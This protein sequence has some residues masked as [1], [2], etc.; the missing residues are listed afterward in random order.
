MFKA[1]MAGYEQQVIAKVASKTYPLCKI[2][3]IISQKLYL[4]SARMQT[5]D[6]ISPLVKDYASPRQRFTLLADEAVRLSRRL[7]DLLEYQTCTV[8]ERRCLVTHLGQELLELWERRHS[9]PTTVRVYKAWTKGKG[10]YE[11]RGQLSVHHLEYVGVPAIMVYE[12]DTD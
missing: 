9:L 10:D 1:A 4:C 2:I 5:T 8:L 11:G 3:N 7:V 12:E 6:N